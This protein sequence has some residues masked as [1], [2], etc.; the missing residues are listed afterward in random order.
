MSKILSDLE[1]GWLVGILEGE[2]CFT[3]DGCPRIQIQMTDEDVI[4][5]IAELFELI[6][7]KTI[8]IHERDTQH[9]NK[10]RQV[11]HAIRVNGDSA[12]MVM[13]TVVRHMGYRRRQRIWQCLNGYKVKHTNLKAAD[14]LQLVVGAK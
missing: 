10:N 7:G 1:L 14:I 11:V 6:I 2:G 4:K 12:R 13:L 3:F 9:I 8:N 5:R